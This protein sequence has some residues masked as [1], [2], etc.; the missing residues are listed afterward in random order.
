[1]IGDPS[2]VE[3]INDEV[4]EK[5]GQAV[6]RILEVGSFV[7]ATFVNLREPYRLSWIK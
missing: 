1:M 2:K 7:S 6:K 3:L 5:A 4:V